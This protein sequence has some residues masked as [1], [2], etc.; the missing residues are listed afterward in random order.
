MAK[1][2]VKRKVTPKKKVP[3]YVA[4]KT[5]L[6]ESIGHWYYGDDMDISNKF[7]FLYLMVNRTEGMAYIGKRQFWKYKKGSMTKTGANTWRL[8]QSSSSHIEECI[9]E[10]DEFSYHMLG[11][12]ETRAWLS[13]G[14]AYL[15]MALDTLTARDAKGNRLWYNNQVA[16]V[17][18]IP[19]QSDT[20]LKTLED[21]FNTA[22]KLTLLIGK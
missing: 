13:Y 15:Q 2:A 18:Y 1:K 19:K 3:K 17:K 14:E 10:G 4:K 20:E 11:V 8:Y 16:P 7:G 9:K 5:M 12:F 6:Q 21:A 22:H